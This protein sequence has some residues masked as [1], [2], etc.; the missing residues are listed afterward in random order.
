MVILK[1][2]DR[3][4]AKVILVCIFLFL[5][6]QFVLRPITEFNKKLDRNLAEK[7]L[8]L[9]EAKKTIKGT[10]RQVIAQESLKRFLLQGSVQEEMTRMIKGIESAATKSGLKILETKPQPQIQNVGWLEIRVG[11]A[12]EGRWS[13][14]VSFLYHVESGPK[15]FFVNEI[16][17]E[18]NLPQQTTI[19]GR[20]DLASIVVLKSNED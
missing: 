12:F 13:D 2:R 17:L 5:W 11:I 8:K 15:L 9:R 7:N 10:L 1:P 18:A 4:I 19:R 16:T 20:L 3:F 6:M 14:I